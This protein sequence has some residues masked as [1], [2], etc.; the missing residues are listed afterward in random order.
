[1]NV[2]IVDDDFENRTLLQ[3][4][5]KPYGGVCHLAANGPEALIAVDGML[6]RKTPYD[7]ICLDVMMP[8]MGGHDVLK[9]IREMERQRGI[10]GSDAVKI[11]MVSALD[12]A[13]SI[14][15]SLVRGA[16][17]GYL[18]KPLDLVKMKKVLAGLGF[19]PAT[20]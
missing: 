5:L 12:D 4:F 6:D 18:T 19:Q 15:K 9:K 14:M 13:K 2:L 16:G 20:S 8:D 10:G 1:M 11:I 7:L 3:E 17:D